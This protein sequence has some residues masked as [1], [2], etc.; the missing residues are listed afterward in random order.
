MILSFFLRTLH[1]IYNI[2][3]CKKFIVIIIPI[4]NYSFISYC[5]RN[6][7]L[8]Y[9]FILIIIRDIFKKSYNGISCEYSINKWDLNLCILF[10]IHFIIFLTQPTTR[11]SVHQWLKQQYILDSN[12]MEIMERNLTVWRKIEKQNHPKVKNLLLRKVNIKTFW[13]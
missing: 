7:I 10:I 8:C 13:F 11:Q 2:G 9:L 1:K 12:T 3:L 4:K 6:W 5:N